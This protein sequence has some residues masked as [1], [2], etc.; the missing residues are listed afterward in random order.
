M[1][2]H[3]HRHTEASG[4]RDDRELREGEVVLAS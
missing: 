1:D 4:F 3:T 2:S